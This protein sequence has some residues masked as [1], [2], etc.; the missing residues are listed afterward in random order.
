MDVADSIYRLFGNSPKWQL[1][2]EGWIGQVLEGKRRK[3]KLVKTRRVEWHETFE[4][5]LDLYQPSVCCLEEIK[6]P[7]SS[8]WNHDTRKTT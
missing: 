7:A 6:D 1:C 8:E 3:I 4:V 2:L 5:F